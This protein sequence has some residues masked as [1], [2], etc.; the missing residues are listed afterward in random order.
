MKLSYYFPGYPS[1]VIYVWFCQRQRQNNNKSKM[2]FSFIIG[3]AA[4]AGIIGSI[5]SAHS[6]RIK[7]SDNSQDK[8]KKSKDENIHLSS[9]MCE[10]NNIGFY[11]NVDNVDETF[12]QM[13][14]WKT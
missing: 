7:F 11:S 3:I 13:Y 1:S 12:R 4:G 10:K 5:H 6:L 9:G 8:H 14:M 2:M